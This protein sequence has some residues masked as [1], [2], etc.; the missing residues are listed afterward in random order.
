MSPDH[1]AHA[2]RAWRFL[3]RDP[4]ARLGLLILL[5]EISPYFVPILSPAQLET[6][7]AFYAGVPLFLVTLVAFQFRLGRIGDDAERRFWNLWT[8]GYGV[9]LVQQV[10]TGLPGIR[11]G[12]W[13]DVLE[14]L[15]F[16]LFYLLIILARPCSC[17]ASSP[18]SS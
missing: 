14:D 17:S 2:G 8:L 15:F 16:V 10:W 6:Y 7:A 5:V 18:T 9:W 3:R 11:R 4:I 1:S 13:Y 12:Y